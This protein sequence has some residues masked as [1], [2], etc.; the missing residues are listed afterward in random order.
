VKGVSVL[1]RKPIRYF[2]VVLLIA[3]STCLLL[4]TVRGSPAGRIDRSAVVHQ[5][6]FVKHANT[7]DTAEFVPPTPAGYVA[8]TRS[9]VDEATTGPQ[10]LVQATSE[11]CDGVSESDLR[12]DQWIASDLHYWTGSQSENAKTYLTLCLSELGSDKDAETNVQQLAQHLVT[13][14]A[15]VGPNLSPVDVSGIPGATGVA[16]RN[17]L[18]RLVFAKSQFVV[19]VAAGGASGTGLGPLTALATDVAESEY[20]E[21]PAN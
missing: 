9:P 3:C 20:H 18:V 8:E 15:N 5:H 17:G 21:L 19:F 7:G 10:L 13:G 12:G 11:I 14:G 6:V 16:T 2:V 4:L 1:N